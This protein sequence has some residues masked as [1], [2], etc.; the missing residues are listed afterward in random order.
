M[1][2]GPSRTLSLLALGCLAIGAVR[3]AR[4]QALDSLAVA[5][6]GT[7][8]TTF[9]TPL[10]VVD[11]NGSLTFANFDV[12]SHNLRHDLR[13]NPLAEADS[14]PDPQPT[15]A[16]EPWC[17]D[18]DGNFKDPLPADGIIGC[19]R[20]WSDS[21]APSLSTP[22]RGNAHL[23]H[24]KIYPFYCTIHPYLQGYLVVTPQNGTPATV[25][26]GGVR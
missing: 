3:V 5:G 23:E 2:R 19:P 15:A 14:S 13:P 4:A 21:I 8:A 9:A 12:A 16:K 17:F 10:V 20:F 11:P 1:T 25:G 24:G 7:F 18:A 6:P 26:A 22:V